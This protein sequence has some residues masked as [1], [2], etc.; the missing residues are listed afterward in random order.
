VTREEPHGER[1]K[2]D[3]RDDPDPMKPVAFRFA[4]LTLNELVVDEFVV[5]E[6]E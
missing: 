3:R 6:I 2:R 5:R 4:E 1:D